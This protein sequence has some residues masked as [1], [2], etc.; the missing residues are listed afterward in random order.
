M[1]VKSDDDRNGP[2][3]PIVKNMGGG[4][5][6]EGAQEGGQERGGQAGRKSGGRLGL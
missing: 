1:V 6:G 4:Q 2:S 3:P 5:T